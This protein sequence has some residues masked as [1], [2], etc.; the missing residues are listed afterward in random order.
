MKQ[1]S[2]R[3]E[4]RPESAVVDLTAYE[5]TTDE[6]AA[7]AV[8]E[9]VLE[10]YRE[11]TDEV[12]ARMRQPSTPTNNIAAGIVLQCETNPRL[13]AEA[14]RALEVAQRAGE[15]RSALDIAIGFYDSPHGV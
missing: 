15:A 2:L 6:T 10:F 11:H 13:R 14:E 12:I 4:R 1:S 3:R 7:T 9:R 8:S 5:N